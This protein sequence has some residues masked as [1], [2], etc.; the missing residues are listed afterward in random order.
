MPTGST[1]TKARKITRNCSLQA[2]PSK[3]RAES[4]K[5]AYLKGYARKQRGL[6]LST[7][8]TKEGCKV[9]LLNDPLAAQKI[10]DQAIKPLGLIPLHPMGALIEEVKLAVGDELE[11]QHA[12]FHGDAAVLRAP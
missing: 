9:W 1:V 10:G 12:P 11:Q 6:A 3:Y 5:E 2:P 7:P 4:R 8:L